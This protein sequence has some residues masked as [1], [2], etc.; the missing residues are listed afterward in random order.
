MQENSQLQL[1]D[2]LLERPL[3]L[4]KVWWQF[5]YSHLNLPT[6]T[7]SELTARAYLCSR[8]LHVKD[9]K[10]FIKATLKIEPEVV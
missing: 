10:L 9:I 5:N 4:S 7:V 6:A 1:Y 8:R 3:K 2:F